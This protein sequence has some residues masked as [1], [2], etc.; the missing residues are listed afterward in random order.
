M[1]KS[2]FCCNRS[3]RSP[4]GTGLKATIAGTG[5]DGIVGGGRGGISVLEKR[6]RADC[7]GSSRSLSLESHIIFL[8][9]LFTQCGQSCAGG[10]ISRAERMWPCVI[11]VI[12]PIKGV[13]LSLSS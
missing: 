13:V 9:S 6:H 12:C 3:I 11:F 7:E 5:V 2:S 8:A 4:Q 10:I 1:G